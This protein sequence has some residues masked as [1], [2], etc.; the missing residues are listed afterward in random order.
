MM[1]EA[2]DALAARFRTMGTAANEVA[3]PPPKIDP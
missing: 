2:L 3:A 1:P